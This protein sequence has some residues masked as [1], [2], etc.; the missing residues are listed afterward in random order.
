[1][2]TRTS[3]RNSKSIW[4]FP[5]T[6]F[7]TTE[8]LGVL[9]SS[10]FHCYDNEPSGDYVD[11]DTY[12]SVWTQG[13]GFT[14]GGIPPNFY[15][16]SPES[17][18][19]PNPTINPEI[20][21]EDS[22]YYSFSYNPTADSNLIVLHNDKVI[23]PVSPTDRTG[24]ITI[25]IPTSLYIGDPIADPPDIIEVFPWNSDS[26]LSSPAEVTPV[27][28]DQLIVIGSGG[29]S[30]GGAATIISVVDPSGIYT[31]VVG[32]RHDTL[33]DRTGATSRDVMIPEPYAITGFIDGNA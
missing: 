33:Y 21:Q 5:L 31:L 3:S 24:L 16:N 1:M 12:Y 4:I 15:G 10:I 28:P 18:D 22:R 17:P 27:S 32:K 30:F 7:L 25:Y 9:N 6:G 2:V 29:I 23:V 26:G 8:N 19:P 13:V 20:K 11:Y 14:G